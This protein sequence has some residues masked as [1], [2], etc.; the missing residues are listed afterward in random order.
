LGQR[1]EKGGGRGIALQPVDDPVGIN[2]VAHRSTGG[3]ED[4]RRLS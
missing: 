3:R 2:E 4:R 1:F